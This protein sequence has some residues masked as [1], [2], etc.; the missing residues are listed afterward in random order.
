MQIIDRELNANRDDFSV[1]RLEVLKTHASVDFET[2]K[3]AHE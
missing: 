1:S 2:N 3:L